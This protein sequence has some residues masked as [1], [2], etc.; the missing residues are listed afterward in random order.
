MRREWN[1]QPFDC[2]SSLLTTR[3]DWHPDFVKFY[4]IINR[5]KILGVYLGGFLSQ[6]MEIRYSNKYLK[7][8]F[9]EPIEV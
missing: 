2:E 1:S 9:I 6:N 5:V 8:Y 7:F 4:A 3:P